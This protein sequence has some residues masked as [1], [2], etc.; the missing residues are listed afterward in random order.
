MAKDY[1]DFKYV[2]PRTM[3][4]LSIALIVMTLCEA[5]AD[6]SPSNKTW[7]LQRAG[8]VKLARVLDVAVPGIANDCCAI[9]AAEM[10]HGADWKAGKKLR[11]NYPELD[12]V[13]RTVQFQS[14]SNI[15]VGF[16]IGYGKL[17]F[18]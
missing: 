3:D 9:L 6:Q 7:L 8:S 12:I 17:V 10:Q 1:T 13:D 2:Y 16:H 11:I 5:L 4:K 15:G 18:S 14:A